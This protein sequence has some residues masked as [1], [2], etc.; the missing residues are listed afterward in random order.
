MAKRKDL[1]KKNILMVTIMMEHFIMGKKMEEEHIYFQM[2][3]IMM[4]I[5]GILNI[6]DM[7][8]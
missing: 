6:M 2:V 1:E 4:D 8:N 3:L 5:L 7:E